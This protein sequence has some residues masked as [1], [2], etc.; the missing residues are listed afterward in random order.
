MMVDKLEYKNY[1]NC[2]FDIYGSLLTIKQQEYF[3]MY[4]FEDLSLREIASVAGVSSNAVSDQIKTIEKAL[5]K[6]EENLNIYSENE[7]RNRALNKIEE[8]LE[9]KNINDDE[10]KKL[11]E[12]IK[13]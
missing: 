7:A 6:Y 1:I 12:E 9:K 10:I 3:K 8:V 5:E 2:L 13:K 4:Y 11:I